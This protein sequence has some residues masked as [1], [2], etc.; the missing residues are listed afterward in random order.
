MTEFNFNCADWYC[1]S[2]V[3]VADDDDDDFYD[4]LDDEKFEI[5]DFHGHK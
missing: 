5:K 2:A 3:A 1:F 4:A